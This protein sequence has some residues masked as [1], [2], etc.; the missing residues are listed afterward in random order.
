M[1]NLI[2]WLI[3]ITS[4]LGMVVMVVEKISLLKKLVLTEEKQKSKISFFEILKIIKKEIKIFEGFLKRKFFSILKNSLK[5]SFKKISKEKKIY[6]T[7]D[8]WE[9]IK[10][11][12][13][14]E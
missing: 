11:V 12:K 1:F 13:E 10:R 5:E 2:I 14:P 7:S 4:F 6:L 9:K 3:L 8:Y